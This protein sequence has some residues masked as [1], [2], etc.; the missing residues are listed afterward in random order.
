VFGTCALPLIEGGV[1]FLG[2]CFPGEREPP[3]ATAV[4]RTRVRAAAV[5]AVMRRLITSLPSGGTDFLVT[6]E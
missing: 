4:A 3:E 6:L 5:T 2:G 1:W